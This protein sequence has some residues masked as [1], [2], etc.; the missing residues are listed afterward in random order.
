MAG[1]KGVKGFGLP[2]TGLDAP[3]VEIESMFSDCVKSASPS[4]MLLW[5][6]DCRRGAPR[7]EEDAIVRWRDPPGS[8]FR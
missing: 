3:E 6:A 2:R 5:S 4:P 8:S 7:L 1:R